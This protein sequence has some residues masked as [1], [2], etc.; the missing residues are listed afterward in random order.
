MCNDFLKTSYPTA[1][2]SFLLEV[3][4]YH[5]PMV[6][7]FYLSI[8]GKK[9][10]KFFG[11]SSGKDSFIEIVK[12]TWC[13]HVNGNVNYQIQKKLKILKYKF[14]QAFSAKPYP[15]IPGLC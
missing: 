7:P 9:P 10:F 13:L 6:V 2:A 11:F 3:E 15:S 5:S 4:F 12:D 1:E 8:S 14:K